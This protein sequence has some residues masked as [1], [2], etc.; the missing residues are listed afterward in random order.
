MTSGDFLM[1]TPRFYRVAYVINPWMEGNVGRTDAEVA[2]RQWERL[3]LAG[4]SRITRSWPGLAPM[5]IQRPCTAGG[6]VRAL[7]TAS[8][9]G[10]RISTPGGSCIRASWGGVKGMGVQAFRDSGVQQS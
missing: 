7:P 9:A 6:T 1:C 3:M 5:V 8:P 4:C 2:M 10:A